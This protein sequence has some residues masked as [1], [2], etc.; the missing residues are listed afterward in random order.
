MAKILLVEDDPDQ[1]REYEIYLESPDGGNHEVDWANSATSAVKMLRTKDYDL[2]LLDIML[3]FQDEDEKNRD[4]DLHDVDY[5]RRM[6]LHVYK[7]ARE[8]SNPPL[9]ALVSVVREISVLNEF[10]EIVGQLPKYFNLDELGKSVKK[11][12]RAD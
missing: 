11:W 2:V 1:G 10:P 7:K 6:G 8:L 3:A 4:I 5:G 9:I 12:L